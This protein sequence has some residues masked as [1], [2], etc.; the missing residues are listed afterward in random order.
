MPPVL[1][2]SKYYLITIYRKDVFLLVVTTREV[3]PLLVVE[4][5]HRVCDI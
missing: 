1:K 5:L 2:T 4:F 3:P